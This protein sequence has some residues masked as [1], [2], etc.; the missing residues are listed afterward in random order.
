MKYTQTTLDKLETVVEKPVM[1]FAMKEA[2]SKAA[3]AYWKKEN[4]WYLNKFLQL[5]GRIN[6]MLD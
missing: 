3:I 5:E 6:T 1:S 4:S 2:L